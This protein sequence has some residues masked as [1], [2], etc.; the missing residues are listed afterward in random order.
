[1][2]DAVADLAARVDRIEARSLATRRDLF[3]RIDWLRAETRGGYAALERMIGGL[4]VVVAQAAGRTEALLA[5][6]EGEDPKVRKLAELATRTTEL[7]ADAATR[8]ARISWLLT[9]VGSVA[10]WVLERFAAA[11]W[12]HFFH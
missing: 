12:S 3:S 6:A 2:G 11:A 5:H 4:R 10:L 7:E 9:A 1:M 8:R